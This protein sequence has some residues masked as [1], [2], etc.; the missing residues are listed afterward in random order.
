MSSSGM[1][2]RDW[3]SRGGEYQAVVLDVLSHLMDILAP[4]L[5]PVR[6][7][8]HAWMVGLEEFLTCNC[9]I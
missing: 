4:S 6:A 7:Q 2:G 5:R 3:Y 1:C 9:L 8:F